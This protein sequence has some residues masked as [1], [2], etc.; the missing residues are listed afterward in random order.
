M[1]L[2]ST[3]ANTTQKCASSHFLPFLPIVEPNHYR[4]T[5]LSHPA[6]HHEQSIEIGLNQAIQSSATRMHNLLQH[7]HTRCIHLSGRQRNKEPAVLTGLSS[8]DASLPHLPEE[9]ENQSTGSRNN[10][11]I[12]VPHARN[13]HL[14]S[15]PSA[16]ERIAA[17]Q[18]DPATP[19]RSKKLG[20]MSNAHPAQRE[21]VRRSH[22]PL[23][24]HISDRDAWQPRGTG[25]QLRQFR[26]RRPVR[27]HPY[28]SSPAE[29]QATAWS[30]GS[31]QESRAWP[32]GSESA[33]ERS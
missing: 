21:I 26:P 32:T 1:D 33:P 11:A 12:L 13:K 2:T 3:N 9:F 6:D 20:G 5:T 17:C 10:S 28:R 29:A 19:Q 24:N 4:A 30:R 16:C 31:E 22:A 23:T 7:R 27:Q 8:F 25:Q 18:L 14:R 15:P